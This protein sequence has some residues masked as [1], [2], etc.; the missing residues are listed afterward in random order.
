MSLSSITK[1]EVPDWIDGLYVWDGR[2]LDVR[3]PARDH[4]GRIR[5]LVEARMGGRPLRSPSDRRLLFDIELLYDNISTDPQI[6]LQAE[7]WLCPLHPQEHYK[8]V[9]G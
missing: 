2:M 6:P 7:P 3:R 8:E 5:N 1:T 4:A 9:T